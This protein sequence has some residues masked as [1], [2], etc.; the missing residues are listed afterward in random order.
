MEENDDSISIILIPSPDDPPKQSEEYQSGISALE[1]S[2][3]SE[4]IAFTSSRYLIESTSGGG[5]ALGEFL[6]A[7]KSVAPLLSGLFGAWLRGKFGRRVKLK[8][9]DLQIEATTVEDVEKL[10]ALVAKHRKK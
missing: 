9:K 4:E 7:A 1:K 8:Y 3:R 5:F 2:M 6:V 10:F